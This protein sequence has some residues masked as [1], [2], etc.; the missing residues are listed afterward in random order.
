MKA[1]MPR[2]FGFIAFAAT[3][4]VIDLETLY[5]LV[6][7]QWP[8]H[9]VLHTYVGATCVGIVVGFIIFLQAWG[10]RRFANSCELEPLEQ[11]LIEWRVDDLTSALVGGIIGGASHV[12]LDSI[13]HADVQPLWPFTSENALHRAISVDGLHL[14]CVVAGLF[15]IGIL[16]VNRPP[17]IGE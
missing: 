9:T 15:G 3:Q 5:H 8:L 2:H 16:L 6:E 4:V 17:R 7:Q 11:R 13:M 12:I 10:I 1:A 14:G